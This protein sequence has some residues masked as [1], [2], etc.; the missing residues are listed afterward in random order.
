[1]LRKRLTEFLEEDLVFG[2]PTTD[3]VVGPSE[4]SAEVVSR[5]DGIAAGIEEGAELLA[6]QGINVVEA[7][8]DGSP[9]SAGDA[10]LRMTGQSRSILK[11]ERTLLNLLS[12]MCGIATI[13][14]AYVR[15]ART[16]NPGVRVAA[17]RKTAPGLRWF[18]KKAV[19]LGGGDPHRIALHDLVLIKDNHIAAAGDLAT[20]LERVKD[21]LSFARKVEVEVGNKEDALLAARAGA[22]IVMMDNMPPDEMSSALSALEEEGLRDG[23]LIEA[24]G[25]ISLANVA[26]VSAT[27]VDIVS[28]GRLTH[29]PESLDMALRL[30]R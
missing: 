13:T 19:V 21:K 16:A 23:V 30:I 10:L 17:T 27:G 9:V 22:D 5:Q 14:S 4:V 11:A 29:S 15:A 24:S 3:L 25:G 18:D 7:V 20:C 8:I 12:R 2:D 28:V 26:E 6:M 1:L